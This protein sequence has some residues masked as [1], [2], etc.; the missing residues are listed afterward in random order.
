LFEQFLSLLYQVFFA[1]HLFG[2]YLVV[3]DAVAP[4]IDYAVPV[5][6]LHIAVLDLLLTLLVLH[7]EFVVLMLQLLILTQ[8]TLYE[9][10]NCITNHHSLLF[11][12]KVL[13]LNVP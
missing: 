2:S 1:S 6:T 12:C 10:L 5:E 3:G 11:N 9:F 4:L 8:Q 7:L 13:A